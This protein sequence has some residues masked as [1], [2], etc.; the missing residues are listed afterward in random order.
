MFQK[1]IVVTGLGAVTP[2]GN[3]VPAFWASLVAAQ[4]GVSSIRAFP[5]NGFCPSYGAEVKA[6]SAETA[7]LP[8]KRIKM[9]GRQAQLAFAAVE[10]ACGDAKL[11][12]DD[13]PTAHAR[14]GIIL[15]VGMMDTDVMELGRAFHATARAQ[16]QGETGDDHS[17]GFDPVAFGHAGA[18]QLF[19]LG[20]LRNIPNLAAAH[21]SIALDAQGPSNTITTGCVAAAN[22]IGEAARVI[23]RGHADVLVAG[24]T[25]ARVTPLGMLRYR[26]LGWLATRADV[27]PVEVS[28]PFDE[29]AAGFV[30]G[31]GA[32]FVV[33]ESLDHARRRGARIYAELSGYS[34]ANDAYDL[35]LPHPKGRALTRALLGCLDRSG[36]GPESPD[37]VFAPASSIPAFDRAIAVSLST[38][39]GTTSEQPVITATRCLLGHTHAASAAL[40]CVAAVKAIGASQLPPT[41]NLK[42][43]IAP[44]RFVGDAVMHTDV[45]TALVAAYGFGG[46]AA[47]LSLRTYSA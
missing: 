5:V 47:V 44:L 37:A 28:A 22:A 2:L 26:G 15:G 1:R 46:H 33:L 38:V 7:N 27:D 8:R 41:I 40:D 11:S 13:S 30:N 45:S 14:L 6:F 31:E 32:G 21:A 24:G 35:L 34:A 10:E 43:P 12:A 36:L 25:D 9:M 19:P 16:E 23:A 17:A 29:S 39:F 42:R 4:S 3:S 18:L 20:M